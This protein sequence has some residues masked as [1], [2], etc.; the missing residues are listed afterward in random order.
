MKVNNDKIIVLAFRFKIV[1]FYE[2]YKL[3]PDSY[4]KII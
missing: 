1:R 3:R 2:E 4:Y